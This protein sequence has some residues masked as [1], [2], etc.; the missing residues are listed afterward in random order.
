[1]TAVVLM[2]T[3][4]ITEFLKSQKVFSFGNETSLCDEYSN[5]F[6][7]FYDNTS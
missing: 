4:C 6:M 2:I 5:L 3:Q 7:P 1:M